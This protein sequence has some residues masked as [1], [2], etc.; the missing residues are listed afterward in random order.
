MSFPALSGDELLAWLEKTTS[1][2]RALLLQHPHVL[3]LPCD[4]AGTKTVGELLQHVVAVGLRY[5]ERLSDAPATE[6]S[7]IPFDTVDAIYATHDRAMD[8]LKHLRDRD[9]E[10]WAASIEFVTRSA[11]TVQA[12]RRDVYFHMLLHGVRHYAQLSTIV[13]QAGVP[14]NWPMD[15]LF[16]GMQ[17]VR[18]A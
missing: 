13:R 14:A 17:P 3:A 1:G 9:A 18:P 16:M 5:A 4:I 11:G 12:T 2:W 7:K 6:Y 10:F 8:L 15:Y